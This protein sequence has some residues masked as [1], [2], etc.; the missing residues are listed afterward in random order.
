MLKTAFEYKEQ[1]QEAYRNITFKERYK[2]YNNGVYWDYALKI[3]E[4][5]WDILQ[6]VSVDPKGNVIGY[7]GAEVQ[8]HNEKV[9][10]LGVCNF[11][12]GPNMIFAKDFKQF[13]S[14]LFFRFNFRK[15]EFTV[16]LGNPAEK[17]YD[18]FIAKYGG[19]VTGIRRETVRLEDGKFYDMKAYE[20]FKEDILKK[21]VLK[22]EP[23]R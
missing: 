15:I 6:M 23:E 12:D 18:R 7:F 3:S 20:V 19:N 2:Y 14:D 1:L 13:L 4:N 21:G 8:R 17:I 22:R 10:S 16:T 11:T 5:S 9:S